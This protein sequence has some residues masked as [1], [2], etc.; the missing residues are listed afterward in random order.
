MLKN[1]PNRLSQRALLE[2]LQATPGVRGRF[3][4]LYLPIDFRN[5]GNGGIGGIGGNGSG[6]GGASFP[7]SFS[8]PSPSPASSSSSSGSSSSSSSTSVIPEPAAAAA[9][10]A[11]PPAPCNLGYAFVNCVDGRA[12]SALVEALHGRAWGAFRS[13]KVCEVRKI[14]FYFFPFSSVVFFLPLNFH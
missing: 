5:G 9:A 4:F 2:T 13:R 11:F 8:F 10:A 1:V 12:A 6:E 7:L 14:F 3:D